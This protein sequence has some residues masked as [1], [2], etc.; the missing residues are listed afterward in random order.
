MSTGWI[1]T[2][3]FAVTFISVFSGVFLAYFLGTRGDRVKRL[4]D[5]DS[6]RVMAKESIANELQNV[7]N[8]AEGYLGTVVQPH[9]GTYLPSDLS[10]MPKT[11]P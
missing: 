7:L 2:I 10:P 8:D 11:Q 1:L 3:S 6:Q 9:P 5:E 4:E